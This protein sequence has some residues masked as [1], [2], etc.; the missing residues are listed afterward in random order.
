W[1]LSTPLAASLRPRILR[2]WKGVGRGQPS[3]LRFGGSAPQPCQIPS[4]A[5][6]PPPAPRV[7]PSPRSRGEGWGEGQLPKPSSGW[8]GADVL[9]VLFASAALGHQEICRLRVL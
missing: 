7:P 9:G 4:A 2:G 3:R 5:A 1:C 6:P 8:S